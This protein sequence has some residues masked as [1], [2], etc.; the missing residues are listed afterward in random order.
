MFS[1]LIGIFSIIL[2]FR[3]GSLMQLLIA[4]SS[5]YM[6]IVTVPFIMALFGFR[7]TEKSVLIGMFTGFLTVILWDYIFSKPFFDLDSLIPAMM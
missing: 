4:T 2:A 7:S 3:E 6:P 5:F 1:A